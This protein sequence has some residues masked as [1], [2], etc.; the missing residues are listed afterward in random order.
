MRLPRINVGWLRRTKTKVQ[1]VTKKATKKVAA[2]KKAG[3]TK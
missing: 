2:K 1:D 3:G